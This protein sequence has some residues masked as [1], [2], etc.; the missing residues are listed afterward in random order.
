MLEDDDYDSS[1]EEV[2]NTKEVVEEEAENAEEVVEE[3][4]LEEN[5]FDAFEAEDI[6]ITPHEIEYIKDKKSLLLEDDFIEYLNKVYSKVILNN[7]KN[8][9]F[10]YAKNTYEHSKKL[11]KEG[12]CKDMAECIAKFLATPVCAA[13][14]AGFNEE[15]L[16]NEADRKAYNEA[17][18]ALT[19]KENAELEIKYK[20]E[21]FDLMKELG[22]SNVRRP[23]EEFY[24][25]GHSKI[26][27]SKRLITSELEKE[28]RDFSDIIIRD[29]SKKYEFYP[30]DQYIKAYM[31]FIIYR[32]A[33][34]E[35]GPLSEDEIRKNYTKS[36]QPLYE[37]MRN[38]YFKNIE[39]KY[40]PKIQARIE[41]KKAIRALNNKDRMSLLK[42]MKESILSGL[43]NKYDMN[44]EEYLMNQRQKFSLMKEA[45]YNQSIWKK[46]FNYPRFRAEQRELVDV[47]QR[48]ASSLHVTTDEVLK[49]VD[50]ENINYNSY[51]KDA[52]ALSL[53]SEKDLNDL[54]K[55]VKDHNLYKTEIIVDDFVV[56]EN[57]YK[58]L[59][60]SVNLDLNKSNS[61]SEEEKSASF[62]NKNK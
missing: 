13:R 56:V 34:T 62:D 29:Y 59:D 14:I 51:I 39:F 27:L 32:S 11:I 41:D 35:R 54:I 5:S 16:A 46:I 18:K 53:K 30:A 43:D 19:E 31:K 24:N 45:V 50:D 57:D 48:L 36:I 10:I 23:F 28:N 42:E 1:E 58:N 21:L 55:E 17:E 12:R 6:L 47:T 38:K 44:R 33:S 3:E 61:I 20:A 40:D 9:Y 4:A 37:E 8:S 52:K 7:F 49:K 2:E 15:A 22:E 26:D 60:K 25:H